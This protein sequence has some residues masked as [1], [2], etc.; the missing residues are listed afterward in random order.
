MALYSLWG[1]VLPQSMDY[2]PLNKDIKLDTKL[3][4]VTTHRHFSSISRLLKASSSFSRCWTFGSVS[5]HHRPQRVMRSKV[6]Q[7]ARL[8]LQHVRHEP[9]WC[10]PWTAEF[11][12]SLHR[13]NPASIPRLCSFLSLTGPGGHSEWADQKIKMHC[14]AFIF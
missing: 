4:F 7:R 1:L 12:V 2:P 5:H 11:W 14:Q 9:C 3:S 6:S 8:S 10:K 13:T